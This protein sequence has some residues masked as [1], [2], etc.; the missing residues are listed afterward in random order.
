MIK[1]ILKEFTENVVK[2]NNTKISKKVLE[3]IEEGRIEGILVD[4]SNNLFEL[5]SPYFDWDDD[6][7]KYYKIKKPKK[8]SNNVFKWIIKQVSKNYNIEFIYKDV[9]KNI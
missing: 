6:H 2:N 3:E 4:T 8:I 9:L 7:F 1:D 5:T